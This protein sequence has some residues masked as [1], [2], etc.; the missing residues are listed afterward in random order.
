MDV[1][2]ILMTTAFLF[3]FSFAIKQQRTINELNKKYL[4]LYDKGWKE[5]YGL[6]KVYRRKYK[7]M[8][9]ENAGDNS[10]L[11]HTA[12]KYHDE[13]YDLDRKKSTDRLLVFVKSEEVEDNGE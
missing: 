10:T 2:F 9:I 1:P 7:Y 8:V 6:D 3:A 5:C 4:D 12:E 13:G 11:N